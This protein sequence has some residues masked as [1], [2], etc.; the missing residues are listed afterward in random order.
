[1]Q[2]EQ[3]L[4]ST[5]TLKSHLQIQFLKLLSDGRVLILHGSLFHNFGP[6]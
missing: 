6:R 2:F 1:M 5:N 3:L 4:S